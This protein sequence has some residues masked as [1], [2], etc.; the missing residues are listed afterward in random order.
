MLSKKVFFKKMRLISIS[1]FGDMYKTVEELNELYIF[2]KDYPDEVFSKGIDALLKKEVSSYPP[3]IGKVISYLDQAL[4]FDM[5]KE[6]FLSVLRVYKA[7]GGE[8][9]QNQKLNLFLERLDI[10]ESI[11]SLS[12]KNKLTYKKEEVIKIGK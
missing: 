3:S 1:T 8:N 5:S 9:Y 10:E 2:F 11:Q 6:D 12:F 7:S 4:Y